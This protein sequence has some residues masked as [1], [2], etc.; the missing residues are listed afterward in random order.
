MPQL[1]GFI[2]GS[3]MAD[4]DQRNGRYSIGHDGLSNQI[5]ESSQIMQAIPL[6]SFMIKS[7]LL[8][9]SLLNTHW[10]LVTL[11]NAV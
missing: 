9:S 7:A 4:R 5:C 6:L 10:V 3:W 2:D 1:R 8:F 11:F